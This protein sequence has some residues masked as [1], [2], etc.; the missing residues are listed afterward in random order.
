MAITQ[1]LLFCL[2]LT[3]LLATNMITLTYQAHQVLS[4]HTPLSRHIMTHLKTAT[5]HAYNLFI[6]HHS[7]TLLWKSFT[8]SGQ[9]P[10]KAAAILRLGNIFSLLVIE[11]LLLASN[12]MRLLLVIRFDW[13]QE[14]DHERLAAQSISA[15]VAAA[16]VL[17]VMSALL[18]VWLAPAVF[19]PQAAPKE[20]Q[21]FLSS[22]MIAVGLAILVIY[23]VA[24]RILHQRAKNNVAI[25][26]AENGRPPAPCCCS[27]SVGSLAISLALFG[28]GIGKTLLALALPP[29]TFDVVYGGLVMSQVMVLYAYGIDVKVRDFATKSWTRSF[30][31]RRRR[32]VPAVVVQAVAVQAGDIQAA[33]VQAAAVQAV[34]VQAGYIQAVVDQAPAIQAATVQAVVV[35]AATVQAATF[36]AG[37]IQAAAAQ[38]AARAAS[39]WA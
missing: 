21:F 15:A 1:P 3:T 36:Q 27:V 6:N 23:A 29:N 37:D 8:A 5:V 28:Y 12:V 34:A 39:P 13:M 33:A 31:R 19:D 7:L 17:S 30:G 26:A 35:Q 16:A 22:L 25:L 18:T 4:P 2:S 10:G 11:G 14:Q 20:G 38:A 32:V 24:S 9:L